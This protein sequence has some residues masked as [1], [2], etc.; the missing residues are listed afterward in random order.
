MSF[1]QVSSD[2][3]LYSKD[4]SGTAIRVGLFMES[5]CFGSYGETNTMRWSVLRIAKELHMDRRTAFRAVS[6]LKK[7]R[8]VT[9]KDDDGET[10]EVKYPPW[11]VAIKPR[12]G[13][14]VEYRLNHRPQSTVRK[15]DKAK[16]M[17]DRPR[18]GGSAT[19]GMADRSRGVGRIG[20]G[21]VADPPRGGDGSA[22]QTRTPKQ[23]LSKQS[24]AVVEELKNGSADLETSQQP[25]PDPSGTPPPGELVERGDYNPERTQ[26]LV[27]R[28]SRQA[29]RE[30]ATGAGYEPAAPTPEVSGPVANLPMYEVSKVIEALPADADPETVQQALEARR[31]ELMNNRHFD[32]DR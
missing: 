22:T 3:L 32:D 12:P 27:M 9:F 24:P 17:T 4:L 23:T 25:E 19:G 10:R 6:E 8:I 1:F 16:G 21:E 30:R 11:I 5:K 26:E 7:S 28:A 15:G 18:G 13:R 2:F 29:A 31:E 14:A 20:H